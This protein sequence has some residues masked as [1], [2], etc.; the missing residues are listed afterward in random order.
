MYGGAYNLFRSELAKVGID[1][2]FVDDVVSVENVKSAL[3]PETK[4]VW[5]EVVT[6]PLISIMDVAKMADIVHGYNKEIIFGI[7]NTFLT[8]YILVMCCRF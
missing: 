5:M 7:D 8:P 6:N 2:T 1:V 4:M 3:R